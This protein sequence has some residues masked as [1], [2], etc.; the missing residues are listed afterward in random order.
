MTD[1]RCITTS[2][3]ALGAAILATTALHSTRADAR[4]H[5]GG[6]KARADGH[7]RMS[8]HI[9]THKGLH[10]G[11]LP[12]G[13]A[14]PGGAGSGNNTSIS[15]IP[16]PS[17]THRLGSATPT[18]IGS[19]GSS[20]IH[21]GFN[22][23]T[24]TPDFPGGRP[25]T[26]TPVGNLPKATP[27]PNPNFP[28]IVTGNKTPGSN[29]PTPTPS[30]NPNFPPIITGNK[31]PGSNLPTPTP[32]P[33]PNFPPV[34]TGNKTPGSN[35]PTPT[36]SPNPN[37]PGTKIPPVVTVPVPTPI[38]V[39]IPTR[40]YPGT[41]T[42]Y[43]YRQ[44]GVYVDIDG[45]GAGYDPC[46]WFRRRYDSTGNVYWLNRYRVCLWRHEAD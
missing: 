1:P 15:L 42:T 38:P 34:V 29:L 27:S 37:L 26:H 2:M 25:G 22:L 8:T 11:H 21:P 5:G 46:W 20:A 31:T 19:I 4:E 30:P 6:H 14:P 18:P 35:L 32:S 28:P 7:S 16:P 9:A 33:N 45:D 36:P 39:P 40:T 17:G 10:G 12:P 23:P 13:S 41:G 3:I 43:A 24:P 44:S